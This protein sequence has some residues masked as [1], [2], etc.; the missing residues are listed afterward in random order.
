MK[1][2]LR[3]WP[4]VSPSSESAP[5]AAGDY[6]EGKKMRR[7]I[8]LT[9]FTM[10]LTAVPSVA[11][12]AV[13]SNDDLAGARPVTSLPYSDT[14]SVG[15]ATTEA[16]EPTETCAPAGNTVWYT[17]T[18][19]SDSDVR[20][21]TV[22]SNY[23]T[24]LAV[25]AG[26]SFEDATLIACTDD[27]FQRLQSALTFSA[28]AGTTYLVQAGAFFQAP[29]DAVLHISFA[30]PKP[31]AR[32][33][34][35]HDKFSGSIAEAYQDSYND[36]TG[37][38]SFAGAQV[39]DGTQK[40][41]GQR[42][43]KFSTL[44]VNTSES[45]FDEANQ[46]Y[47]STDWFGVVDLSP[48]QFS[49][50]KRLGGASVIAAVTMYGSACI[51]DYIN[52]TYECTD[53]GSA[54][55]TAN[56][57]WSAQG[58]LIRSNYRSTDDY[59]G[60]RM[61]FSGRSTSRDAAVTG[62]VEGDISID[63]TGATGRLSNQ[64]SGSWFWA[65]ADAGGEYFGSS[66]MTSSSLLD[67]TALAGTPSIMFDRFTG[68]FAQA[69]EDN[70]DGSTGTYQTHEVSL[71]SGRS[72]IKGEKWVSSNDVFVYSSEGTFDDVAQT[73]TSTSWFG[74]A[75]VSKNEFAI[76]K[77]L[78]SA[79]VTV[80]VPLS[81]ET[82]TYSFQEDTYDCVSIGE[83]VVDVN[84]TWTG[85]GSAYQSSSSYQDRVEN[86]TISFRGRFSGRS[87]TVA[88]TVSGD[89]IGWTF[90]NAYGQLGNQSYGNWYKG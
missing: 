33:I 72:K 5:D 27:T 21:D 62:G 49:I 74:G 61:R 79:H 47:T 76:A 16:G 12:A 17:V 66:T 32:P 43:Q 60:F 30:K 78:G 36:V 84:V 18:V 64:A 46:V 55:V 63:L 65:S 23:D 56:L 68:S 3:N 2:L 15:D 24:T 53:L 89:G 59:G 7:M 22:D 75:P 51:D 44:F 69:Y 40:T 26:S 11:M 38:Y 29:P 10:I 48:G 87:A 81:G 52:E 86:A 37:G 88:G 57:A 6:P 71:T 73:A 67:G 90:D 25:W 70:Y 1:P 14:V 28:K 35:N 80:S 34:V 31:G 82:C 41:K 39:I 45:A 50:D 77:K 85:I 42:L 20:I 9:V 54:D 58:K 19:G 4:W 13:P 83:K 8:Y